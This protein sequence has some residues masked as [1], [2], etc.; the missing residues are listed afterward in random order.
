MQCKAIGESPAKQ[1]PPLFDPRSYCIV[2]VIG[3]EIKSG[4]IPAAF[5]YRPFAIYLH[6]MLSPG[7]KVTLPAPT[8]ERV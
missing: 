3:G 7:Y 4:G 8:L 6:S 1:S 2:T 5:T